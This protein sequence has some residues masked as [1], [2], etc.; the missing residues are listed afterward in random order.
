MTS[1]TAF[2]NYLEYWCA[3]IER[4][5]APFIDPGSTLEVDKI[6]NN[7]L[8]ANWEQKHKRYEADFVV[9]IDEGVSVFLKERRHSYKSF[10]A[11]SEMADL[12]GLA[13]IIARTKS[14]SIFVETKARRLDESDPAAGP[15]MQEID[16]ALHDSAGSESTL[17]VMVTGEAGAGKTS[18]LQHMVAERANQY[19]RGKADS[20]FLYI[21]AQGRALARFNEALA[22]ELSD[23]RANVTYH[24]VSTLV[25][26]GILVP[27]IDGFDELL[28]VGGY[29]D[30]FSS[31]AAF[32]EELDGSGRIVASARNT[33]YEQ[34]FVAR[35][36]RVSALGSQIWKQIPVEVLAWGAEEFDEY[37]AKRAGAFADAAVRDDF[38]SKVV[39]AFKGEN[40]KLKTKPLFVSKTADLIISG[41][42]LSGNTHL[43]DEL[44][45][46][47]LE[48]ERTEKLLDRFGG[49]LLTSQQLRELMA[50]LAEEMWNQQTRA[51]DQQGVREVAEYVLSNEGIGEVAY[52]VVTER[53][54]T[55][56]FLVGGDRAG[57]ISFEHETFF[58]YFLAD[59]FGKS[60]R[61][62]GF[63]LAGLLGRSVLPDDV[64]SI[65]ARMLVPGIAD[66]DM[67]KLLD[68]LSN[69]GVARSSRIAQIQENAGLIVRHLISKRC[70]LN[71]TISGVTLKNLVI[72]GGSMENVI[73]SGSIFENI[74]FRRVN[75]SGCRIRASRGVNVVFQEPLINLE[76]TTIQ[77]SGVSLANEVFGIRVVAESGVQ[78]IYD[79]VEIQNVLVRI[80]LTSP[81]ESRSGAGRQV[82][83]E[84]FAL[85]EKLVR[86]YKRSNPVCT[87]DDTLASIF[88]HS[89]WPDVELMLLESGVAT[90]ERRATSGTP[91]P[92]LRRQVQPEQIMLG[93]WRDAEV[94][95]EV[96]KFWDAM[97]AAFPPGR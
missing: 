50:T 25:R 23:L 69:A 71:G 91:K 39:A 84:E 15:A 11:S 4:D 72:P 36:N 42:V 40:S 21:N 27:V 92:F 35:A 97:E 59:R 80:G 68:N 76:T 6:S 3:R 9:S 60:L 67:T 64:A 93:V 90:L 96:A 34:E 52:A 46:A 65:S 73:I 48:R 51:I 94:P 17:V 61:E 44:V 20:L 29:D 85:I 28:G 62:G 49:S 18:V 79:P 32:I 70:E 53:I 12:L 45:S 57:T 8:Q 19:V 22:T 43:L 30:A 89:S 13:K 31:L 82:K 86:A 77:I 37:L 87:G 38:T 81:G 1:K 41:S 26:L 58:S 63:A 5:L 83:R 56:A 95:V 74:E 88:L 10:F 47:Y 24:A 66:V 7:R 33:Y 54:T 14:G 2:S 55:L 16:M 75:F 78:T